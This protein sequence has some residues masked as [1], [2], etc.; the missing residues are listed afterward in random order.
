MKIVS[1]C[2]CCGGDK[3]AKNPAVLMPFVAHRVFGWQP[4]EITKEWGLNTI[5]SGRAYSVCNTLYCQDCELL[6]LD[7]RF[8]NDEI[9]ALYAGY[10]DEEYTALRDFYEPGYRQRSDILYAGLPHVPEIEKFLAP[11]LNFPI[12]V[13]D[14]GGDTGVNTP[15]KNSSIE[16]YDISNTL[17]MYGKKIDNP[18]ANYDLIVCANVFEH[19]PYPA[20]LLADIKKIMR[21]DT[22]LSIEVPL[23]EIPYQKKRHWHEHVNFFTPLSLEKLLTRCGL[24]II[25]TIQMEVLSYRPYLVACKLEIK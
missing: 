1:S 22:V 25:N 13:L 24:S 12:R 8:D 15:F 7:M 10:R 16:I 14:W 5:P 20:D 4:V 18:L 19:V 11:Y 21:P 2:V 6:F 3:L 17:V 9:A 23:D